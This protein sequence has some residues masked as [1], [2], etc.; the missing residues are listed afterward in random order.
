MDIL[1]SNLEA[2]LA[3]NP[4]LAAKVLTITENTKFEVFVDK[5]PTNINLISKSDWTPMF[6]GTPIAETE[7]IYNDLSKFNRYPY[8]YFFGLGNGI[9]YKM[10]LNN[11]MHQRIVVFEPEVEII[12]I[13]LSMIDFSREILDKRLQIELV[14]DITFD[15]MVNT[16]FNGTPKLYAKVYDLLTPVRYYERYSD[17]LVNINYMAVEALKHLAYSIGN[18]VIDSM[19]GVE[20]HI[21][22]LPRMIHS[23]ILRDTLIKAKNTS[24]AVV[25]ATGPSLAKQLPLL[26]EYAPYVTILSVDASFPILA[27]NDIKPDAVFSIERVALTGSFYKKTAPEAFDGVNFIVSSV[28]HKELIENIKGGT[29][30]LNMRPFGYLQSF[31]HEAWGYLGSGMSSANMAYEFAA[32][33]GFETVVLIGQDLAYGKD[34]L[35]HSSGHIFGDDEV[36]QKASDLYTTAYG[37]DGEVKTTLVWKMFKNYYE[38]AIAQMNAAGHTKT[39]NATEGGA[40]IEGAIEIPFGDLLNEYAD[41]SQIKIPIQLEAPQSEEVEKAVKQIYSTVKDFF[42]YGNDVKSQAEKTFLKVAEETEMLEKMQ[43]EN[44]LDEIDFDRLLALNEEIDSVKALIE[45]ERFDQMYGTV[46][47]PLMLHQEIELATIMVRYSEGE[48]EKKV[49]LIDWIYAHKFWLFSLAGAIQNVLDVI[50]RG[51]L[52]WDKNGELDETIQMCEEYA[53]SR[54]GIEKAAN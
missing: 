46:L 40:R 26:K 6:I 17:E 53:L 52:T 21:Q 47:M 15:V 24:V 37:G 12:F 50:A 11:K 30:E 3:V 45:E 42:D 34:G 32:K 28:A 54:G 19:I 20:H 48:M 9:L 2:L 51:V 18:D 22:N 4:L 31:G 41:R 7:A 10:L 33:A 38:M 16:I 49:K 43:A 14:E 13:V 27:A 8:L 29:L 1:K 23:P 39:Y 25:V 5:D 35:S 36:K 44:R